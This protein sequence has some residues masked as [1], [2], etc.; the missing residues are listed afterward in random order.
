MIPDLSTMLTDIGRLLGFII[1]SIFLIILS[2][3]IYLILDCHLGKVIRF[4]IITTALLLT[5]SGAYS[6]LV[7]LITLVYEVHSFTEPGLKD[8]DEIFINL[9]HL[10]EYLLIGTT[11]F[12]IAKRLMIEPYFNS[13]RDAGDAK[14]Q[15][16]IPDLEKHIIGMVVATISVAFIG[17]VVKGDTADIILKFGIGVGAFITSLGLYVKLSSNKY[18]VALDNLRQEIMQ[19]YA[20]CNKSRQDQTQDITELQDEE[21]CQGIPRNI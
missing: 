7:G 20:K 1:V 17:F 19:L 13:E 8:T 4:F 11:F 3:I 18:N 9:I 10:A 16:D 14:S 2:A 12:S 15:N 21:Q 5:L 6:F